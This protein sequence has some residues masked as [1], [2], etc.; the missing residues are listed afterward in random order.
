MI[1]LIKKYL[2]YIL[3]AVVALV[4]SGIISPNIDFLKNS[5]IK[6]KEKQI[7]Q[8]EKEREE[9][10]QSANEHKSNSEKYQKEF[11][12]LQADNQKKDQ[13]LKI[14]D[15][16]ILIMKNT[17]DSLDIKIDISDSTLA[18]IDKEEYEILNDNSNSSINEHKQFFTDFI[19]AK[20][21]R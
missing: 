10:L 4:V 12:N 1:D 19:I 16:Y 3:V 7:E 15:Q 2:P 21:N 8:L 20:S 11:E 17:L 5:E 13:E 14:R 9:Y 18:K 6:D